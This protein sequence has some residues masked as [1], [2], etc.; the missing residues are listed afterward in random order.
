VELLEI[1]KYQ[2]TI[3]RRNSLYWISLTLFAL[4][5]IGLVA[6]PEF[7]EGVMATLFR[8]TPGGRRAAVHRVV[9][10]LDRAI[11]AYTQAIRERAL[12]K[13]EVAFHQAEDRAEQVRIMGEIEKYEPYL[14]T[15][16][17]R[18]EELQA[19]RVRLAV[20]AGMPPRIDKEF[21]LMSDHDENDIPEI[22]EQFFESVAY[23]GALRGFARFAKGLLWASIDR[24]IPKEI[25]SQMP[26]ELHVV[27]DLPQLL[28]W[29]RVK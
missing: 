16:C 24:A 6:V 26:W 27:A 10:E 18:I 22:V 15:I 28:N 19:E 20:R 21:P 13:K 2:D 5:V 7:A 3:R 23:N 1:W 9:R 29:L 11:K 12:D 14:A 25:L 8:D 17:R 4:V